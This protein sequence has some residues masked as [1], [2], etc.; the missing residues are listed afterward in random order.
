MMDRLHA[1]IAVLITLLYL[2]AVGQDEF[3]DQS[4]E[5]RF[6]QIYKT[7][8]EKPVDG[9]LWQQVQTAETVNAYQVQRG[10]TLWDLSQ[11]FF[12]DP[13]YWPKIWSINKSEILN[14]HEIFPGQSIQFIAGSLDFPPEILSE[15]KVDVKSFVIPKTE[16]RVLPLGALPPSLP[17]TSFQPPSF[18]QAKVIGKPFFSGSGKNY[19]SY[20]ESMALATP[21]D[22][23]GEIVETDM[24]FKTASEFQSVFVKFRSSP[25]KKRFS[26]VKNSFEVK[27]PS[28]KSKGQVVQIQGE[29]ELAEQVSIADNVFRATVTRNLNPIE[30]GALVSEMEIPTYDL[31]PGPVESA[32]L[33][34][35][36]G[37]ASD[38]MNLFGAGNLVLIGGPARDEL[39]VGKTFNVYKNQEARNP[40]S[41][42]KVNDVVIGK[43][44]VVHADDLMATAIVLDSS[45]EIRL[46]DKLNP[47][48]SE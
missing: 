42:A 12:A 39:A 48:K 26:V 43:I 22:G 5:D 14:P 16:R 38:R 1:L 17:E 24:S 29:I 47:S 6:F 23:V 10:D 9:Q 40:K 36:A 41:F 28:S 33:Q 13:L 45:E 30:V 15:G 34:I 2:P 21:I 31:V 20:L 7:Y 11:L 46:G 8:N 44:K 19:A 3:V 35:F 32:E 25:T 37:T 18:E 4:K 27:D